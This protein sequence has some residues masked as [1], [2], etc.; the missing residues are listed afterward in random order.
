SVALPFVKPPLWQGLRL[1]RRY[2]FPTET[3][4]PLVP[5][6]KYLRRD[7]RYRENGERHPPDQ[8]CRECPS[9][10][11][12]RASPRFLSLPDSR[13]APEL[14]RILRLRDTAARR[15]PA[16]LAALQSL[17]REQQHGGCAQLT[18]EYPKN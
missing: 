18:R 15:T 7:R 8:Y 12:R 14:S 4:P 13:Q 11:D 2:V 6:P 17:C 10:A 5:W 1:P 9:D 3:R 16:D